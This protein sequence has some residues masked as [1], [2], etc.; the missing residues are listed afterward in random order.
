MPGIYLRAERRIR[1]E[2]R[3]DGHQG[4]PTFAK[5]CGSFA[6]RPAESRYQPSGGAVPA[7]SGIPAR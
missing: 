7:A 6:H 4:L 1:R 3:A 2:G 5:A